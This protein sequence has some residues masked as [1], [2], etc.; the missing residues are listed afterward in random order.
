MAEYPGAIKLMQ[1]SNK[2]RQVEAPVHAFVT[3]TETAMALIREGLYIPKL[4][5]T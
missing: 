3:Q 4:L 5:H 1:A 2:H